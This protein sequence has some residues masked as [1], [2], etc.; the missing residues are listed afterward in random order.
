[1]ILVLAYSL[2]SQPEEVEAEQAFI[3]QNYKFKGQSRAQMRGWAQQMKH[4]VEQ[5][6]SLAHQKT[7][8]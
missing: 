1:M 4:Y 5:Y 3:S 2:N 8:G 6:S 7:M